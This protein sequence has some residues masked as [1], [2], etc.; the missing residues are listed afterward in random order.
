MTDNPGADSPAPWSATSARPPLAR[1]DVRHEVN[2]LL[3]AIATRRFRIPL[4]WTVLDKAGSSNQR[5][6]IALM[7]RYLA[8]FAPDTIA[9]LLAD[10]EFI[11]GHWIK[12]LL[13]NNILFAIRVKETSAIRLADGRRHLLKDLLRKPAGFKILQSRA[14]RLETMEESSGTPLSFAANTR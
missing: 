11:G 2:I 4:M 10:R 13:D 1:C 12:F 8:L 7:R 14:A 5:E 3:L 9:W 6:R